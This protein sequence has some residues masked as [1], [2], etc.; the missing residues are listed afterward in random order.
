VFSADQV[1][2]PSFYTSAYG[3]RLRASLFPS[4]TGSGEDTHLSIYIRV[5]A[6]DYD[7]LLDWPFRLPMS[8]ILCDQDAQRRQHIVESFVPSA[9]GCR[10]FQ[11]PPTRDS[12]SRDSLDS[13]GGSGV[14]F[15][16]PRFVSLDQLR[17]GT[18]V[19]D[20]TIFVKFKVDQT[21]PVVEHC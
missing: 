6:G 13:G 15:G 3:Y 16:Y 2:S 9:T 7:A 1:K 21:M 20:D 14:G 17:A 5:V 12:T 11:R 19:R 18:Y 10:Q 4:G 8:V